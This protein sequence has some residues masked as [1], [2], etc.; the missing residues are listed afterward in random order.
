M[1]IKVIKWARETPSNAISAFLKRAAF[2]P[3]AETAARAVLEDIRLNGDA[4]VIK[5][6]KD[7]DG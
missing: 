2:D 1:D 6:V 3:T 7:F 5:H 4:A